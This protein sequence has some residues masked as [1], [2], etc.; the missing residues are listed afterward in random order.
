MSHNLR[1]SHPAEKVNENAKTT[2][3]DAPIFNEKDS[4]EDPMSGLSM[5][6]KRG[7]LSC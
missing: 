1:D 5:S 2:N 6:E 7:D 4:N 3:H